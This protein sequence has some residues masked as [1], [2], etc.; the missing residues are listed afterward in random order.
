V[1]NTT[2]NTQIQFLFAKPIYLQLI[3]VMFGPQEK[4]FKLLN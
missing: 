2:V 1:T 3:Q 4:T